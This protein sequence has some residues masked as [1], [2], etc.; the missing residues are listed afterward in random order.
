V[1]KYASLK[2]LSFVVQGFKSLPSYPKE[3]CREKVCFLSTINTEF[4]V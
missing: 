2:S 4:I 3:S 1:A